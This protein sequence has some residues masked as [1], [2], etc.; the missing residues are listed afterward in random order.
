MDLA[1][2]QVDE[3]RRAVGSRR[4]AREH[5]PECGR[6]AEGL[7]LGSLRAFARH[8]DVARHARAQHDRAEELDGDASSRADDR[9]RELGRRTGP[10]RADH[11]VLL[12]A[13]RRERNAEAAVRPRHGVAGSAD[14]RLARASQRDRRARDG[15]P[16]LVH[17][18]PHE[19]FRELGRR[20]QAGPVA[21]VRRSPPHPRRQPERYEQE[22][23]ADDAR[24]RHGPIL[25]GPRRA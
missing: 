24:E 18:A 9:H 25:Q 3:A 7:D 2:R 10:R 16:L 1:C 13:P 15:P 12:L 23:D 19:R 14:E 11:E 8:H 5:V 22:A 17:D 20:R 21:R 6:S 4:R